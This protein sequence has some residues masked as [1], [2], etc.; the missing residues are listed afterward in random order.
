MSILKKL[1]YHPN[2][3]LEFF[4]PLRSRN[5]Q[6]TFICVLTGLRTDQYDRIMRW[7]ISKTQSGIDIVLESAAYCFLILPR[8]PCYS[9]PHRS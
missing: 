4:K 6:R 3:F 8:R 7:W 5:Y 9:S 2:I 1:H